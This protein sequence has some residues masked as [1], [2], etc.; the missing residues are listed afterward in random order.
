MFPRCPGVLQCDNGTGFKGACRI[1]LRTHG[2]PIVHSK[3][4]TPQTNSL[5]Q[6]ANHVLNMKNLAWIGDNNCKLWWLALPEAI[7]AMNR[8][9]IEARYAVAHSWAT[10]IDSGIRTAGGS[11]RG[12]GALTYVNRHAASFRTEAQLLAR[13]RACDVDHQCAFGLRLNQCCE[14]LV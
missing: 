12:W 1:L 7:I 11:A 8:E 3:P 9:T 6:Q 5:I 4:R 13:W 2:I 10:T 14:L